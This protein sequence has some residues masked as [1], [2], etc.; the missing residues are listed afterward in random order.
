[1]NADASRWSDEGGKLF[2]RGAKGGTAVT[3]QKKKLLIFSLS[4]GDSV[5]SW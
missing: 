4:C 1:M 5:I 2:S 3:Q